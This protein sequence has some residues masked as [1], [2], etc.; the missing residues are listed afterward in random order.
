VSSHPKIGPN[1]S[2]KWKAGIEKFR[3]KNP[4]AKT[5]FPD[6]FIEKGANLSIVF[7]WFGEGLV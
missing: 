3:S 7:T 4:D 1:T 5:A 2:D 6:A